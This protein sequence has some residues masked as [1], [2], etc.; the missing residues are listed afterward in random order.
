MRVAVWNMMNPARSMARHE[1][2]LPASTKM[3]ARRR[4]LAWANCWSRR[5][6]AVKSPRPPPGRRRERIVEVHLVGARDEQCG[7]SPRPTPGRAVSRA[8]SH[9]IGAG[10]ATAAGLP[11]A[12]PLRRPPDASRVP[13][14][15]AAAGESH[16]SISTPAGQ[17]AAVGRVEVAFVESRRERTDRLL[18]RAASHLARMACT[19]WGSSGASRTAVS[20]PDSRRWH[21]PRR[22]EAADQECRDAEIIM[23]ERQPSMV[24]QAAAV[25][26]CPLRPRARWPILHRDERP[27]DG[28]GPLHANDAG[29]VRA[30]HQAVRRHRGPRCDRPRRRARGAVLPPRAQRLR[31]VDPSPPDRRAPRPR[32]R[33]HPVRRP[34][35]DR[36]GHRAAQRG[37]VLPELRACGRT[38][39]C[40][41]TC[42][43]GSTS[44][45]ARAER[46]QRERVDEVLRL[47]PDVGLRRAHGRTSC[48]AGSSSGWP[49]PGRW[50]CTPI[51]LLLDEPLSNL[52][53]RLRLEMRGEIRRICKDTG[54]TTIYVTHE[55]KEALSIADRVAIL[56]RGRVEQIGA[57]RDVLPAP[58][59]RFVAGF[60]GETNLL[61]RPRGAARRRPRRARAPRSV[62]SPAP[63][64]PEEPLAAG[65]D[66]TLSI[67]PESIELDAPAAAP[68]APSPPLPRQRLPRRDRPAPDPRRTAGGDRDRWVSVHWISLA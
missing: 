33:A 68:P 16:I 67:R 9:D 40:A 26:G 45:P 43:S 39:P 17:G 62:R 60:I 32:P 41:R 19:V 25:R 48:R 36:A 28:H 15:P 63:R 21:L 42:A 29:A 27:P 13:T 54:S 46:Q 6:S 2:T 44:R 55:Q 34:R 47:G 1:G 51:C 66:V 31:E 11:L 8:V 3:R 56:D 50:W 22:I 37:D 58:A 57:P 49:S 10:P 23:V 59:S 65:D 4:P 61:S 18:S 24:R 35:R 12:E 52:D 14:G 5:S 20:P 53:A 64:L 30:D 7:R 38:S